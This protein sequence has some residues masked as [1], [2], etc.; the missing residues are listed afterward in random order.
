MKDSINRIFKKFL[1]NLRVKNNS[2]YYL[3]KP[4]IP[5]SFQLYIRR[6]FIKYMLTQFTDTWPIKE[7]ACNPR[8]IFSGWPDNKKFALVLS[9]DVDTWK[10]QRNC[11]ALANI[12]E[13]LGLR[14]S[15]NFVPEKYKVDSDLRKHLADKGFEIGVHGLNHDGKLY[16]NRNVFHERADKINKYLKEW[17]AIGFRSPSMHH[18][19]EWIHELDIE[20]DSSSF[21]TDPFEPQPDGAETIFP[22]LVQYEKDKHCYVELPYTLPQDFTL[23]I[24]M[25]E[26]NIEIWKRKLDWIVENGGMALVVSHP[27]FMHFGR[28]SMGREEYPAE[29]YEEFLEY[30]KNNYNGMYWHAL[31][32][33]VAR[34]WSTARIK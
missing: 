1:H 24:L 20:Y 15:F 33:E 12:E 34:F 23:F 10:G 5:R 6:K 3:L 11:L 2:L 13:K 17:D 18:N 16:T 32:R 14:S 9:H 27:D 8:E 29:Y 4:V 22:F 25:E 31:P 30:I 7:S 28:G 19:L 21:D 26:K